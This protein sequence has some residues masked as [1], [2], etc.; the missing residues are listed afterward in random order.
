MDKLI[1]F[2]RNQLFFII[3]IIIQINLIAQEPQRISSSPF[4]YST[5]PD[6]VYIIYDQNFSEEEI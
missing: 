6:T 5:N 1:D 3:G 2:L 4:P